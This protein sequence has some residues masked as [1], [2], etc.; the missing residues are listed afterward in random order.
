MNSRAPK[1]WPLAVAVA[2]I[3]AA[4]NASASGPVDTREGLHFGKGPSDH[5]VLDTAGTSRYI[6]RFTEP[7]LA[8]YHGN[9]PGYAAP[10]RK[11][12]AH[13]RSKLDPNSTQATSYVAMLASKQDQR[14]NAIGKALGRGVKPVHAMQH[15]LNA[16]VLELDASEVARVKKID[17]V[18][19]VE[20][21]VI[22]QVSSDIGPGFIGASSL[23]WGEP[24]TEDTLFISGMEN[25]QKFMGDGVVIGDLDTGYNSKS[26]SFAATDDKG[27]AITN[28][29]GH[30][31]YIGQCSSYGI[32][33]GGCNDKVIGVWDFVSYGVSVEDNV[34]HGSHTGSTAGGNSRPATLGGYKAHISGVAPHANLVIYRVCDANGCPGSSIDAAVDQAIADGIIDV[35]NFSISG[36]SSPWKDSNSQSFLAAE[37]AGIFVAAA[38]GN[39]SASVPKPL[40]GTTNHQ[41]PWT[42][43]VAASTHT[44]GPI[45]F[46]LMVSGAGAPNV[47]LE[48]AVTGAQLSAPFPAT[49][50]QVSPTYG[51]AGDGCTTYP[52]GAFTGKIALLKF[53]GNPPCNTDTRAGNAKAAGAAAVVIGSADSQFITSGANQTVPVFTTPGTQTDLL[54]NYVLAHPGATASIGFPATTRAPMTPDALG[55]FSLIGPAFTNVIKPDVQAP[56]VQILAAIANDNSANGPNLVGLYDGT[57]MATPHTTGTAALLVQMHP[58]WTPMQIKSALMMTAREAGLTKPDGITPSDFYDRGAGRIEAEVASRAGLVLDE[59]QANFQAAD[60]SKGGDPA[61]LNLASMDQTRCID[62]ATKTLHCSFTRHLSSAL[63]HAVN[64]TATLIG[65]VAG[66][67]VSTPAF[68]VLAHDAAS[69]TVTVDASALSTGDAHFGELVLTPDDGSPVLHMPISVSVPPPAI[70]VASTSLTLD[71]PS[72]ATTKTADLQ[73]ANTGGPTLSVDTN[74]TTAG[75]FPYVILDQPI[76]KDY[77]GF[78]SSYD[79]DAA[80]GIY[81]AQNFQV[82]DSS[83]DL[84]RIVARGFM[85]TVPFDYLYGNPVHFRIYRDAPGGGKPDGSPENNTP[86]SNPPVWSYDPQVGD[87]DL[88]TANDTITLDL[89]VNGQSTSLPA[90]SYWLVVYPEMADIYMGWAWFGSDVNSGSTAVGFYAGNGPDW[91]A[92]TD[93]GGGMAVRIEQKITCGAPWLGATPAQLN[94]GA[95]ASGTASVSVDSTKFAGGNPATGYLCLHSND[96]ATPLKIVRVKA[97]QH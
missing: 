75:T 90:G 25:T 63:D 88:D 70:A 2:A 39:T 65:D 85:T 30:G 33:L 86:L 96:A 6:V 59:T 84:A 38:A 37:D 95:L 53:D 55:S 23:W 71:I 7:A 61:A 31:H 1:R 78:Y 43:T 9:L 80:V 56:G 19:A 3:V 45:T 22:H 4:T 52:A 27:Y 44:G 46:P 51:L 93:P 74:Y 83:T 24:A 11:K 17:G 15:A 42:M 81:A 36:G 68:Q 76:T 94:L 64:W 40:P 8:S 49:A 50:L 69:I 89:T 13:G 62:P 16:V 72:G 60:P 47:G 58:D 32:S 66:G 14:L 26:P 5:A 79:T 82:T 12:N 87:W 34:G 48:A 28:P 41:E 67:S 77:Y 54:A 21:D 97:M 91:T 73:V 35:I 10:S 18:V 29:L 57:S 20:P 92:H